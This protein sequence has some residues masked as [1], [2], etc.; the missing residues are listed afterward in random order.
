M[1]MG[2]D[3]FGGRSVNIGRA[4]RFQECLD[5]C[6]MM[7][8]GFTGPRYTWSNHRPLSDL[9]QEQINRVFVNSKWNDLYPKAAVFHL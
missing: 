1:L 7:D 6:R 8:S 3:K 5:N 4:M 9:V 2:D